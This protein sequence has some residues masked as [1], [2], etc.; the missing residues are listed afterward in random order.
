MYGQQM[1]HGAHGDML[2]AVQL[3]DGDAAALISA[4]LLLH[5]EHVVPVLERHRHWCVLDSLST[6]AQNLRNT[7]KT[8]SR[9]KF[10]KSCTR[11]RYLQDPKAKETG[12]NYHTGSRH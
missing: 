9:S 11:L 2:D 12:D 5:S 4:S 10:Q 7:P 6:L 8:L 1:G 3:S